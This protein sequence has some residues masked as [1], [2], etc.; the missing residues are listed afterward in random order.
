M[1]KDTKW[2]VGLDFSEG[3]EELITYVDQLSRIFKPEKI[4]FVHVEEDLEIPE[5]I[6]NTFPEIKE[7][8]DETLKGKLE[9]EV[10]NNFKN[11]DVKVES[12]VLEGIPLKQILHTIQIKKID[13]FIVRKKD[14]SMGSGLVPQKVARKASCSIFF[15][16]EGKKPEF[17]NVLIPCDFSK[18]CK[19][20]LQ[21]VQ[22]IKTYNPEARV[23]LLNIYKVP[24]GYYKTGKTY[25]EFSE[26]MKGHAQKTY[27][28]VMQK[29]NL[30][31][32]QFHCSFIR[33]DYHDISKHILE[34]VEKIKPDIILMG[35][36]GEGAAYHFLLG[37]VTEKFISKNLDYPLIILKIKN[38]NLGL[39]EAIMDI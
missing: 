3:E 8:L 21:A 30:N 4:Y 2:M 39:M 37:S 36:K 22:Q 29:L 34:E 25:E 10:R 20:S 7:P 5:D 16:P 15:V 27:G 28:K 6:L 32:D 26:I 23:Q 38:E 18:H 35:S 12:L 17:D 1:F 19:L 14:I 13:L 11:N 33:K 31:P 9:D 24:V